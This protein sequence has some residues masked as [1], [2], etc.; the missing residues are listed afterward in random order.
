MEWYVLCSTDGDELESRKQW[1]EC[2]CGGSRVVCDSDTGDHIDIS[3]VLRGPNT[4]R[5]STQ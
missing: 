1:C 5:L 4:E 3:S 2:V